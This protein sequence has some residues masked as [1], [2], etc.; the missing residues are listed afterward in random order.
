MTDKSVDLQV[1]DFLS[2]PCQ[3]CPS[4]TSCTSRLYPCDINTSMFVESIRSNKI[5][6]LETKVRDFEAK[7]DLF[8][9]FVES[10][11]ELLTTEKFCK[12]GSY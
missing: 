7:C 8:R 1:W 6:Y 2:Y 10:T 4:P 9:S 12:K 5:C 11:L 3:L